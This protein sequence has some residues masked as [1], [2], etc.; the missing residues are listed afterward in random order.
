[1]GVAVGRA[2]Q[3][4]ATGLHPTRGGFHGSQPA[5]DVVDAARTFYGLPEVLG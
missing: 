2:A 4:A 1:V 5:R 3:H